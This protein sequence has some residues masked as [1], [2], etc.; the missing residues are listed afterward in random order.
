LEKSLAHFWLTLQVTSP[1]R[2]MT[3]GIPRAFA[4]ERIAV[5]GGA[6]YQRELRSRI[7][8]WVGRRPIARLSSLP[9]ANRSWPIPVETLPPLPAGGSPP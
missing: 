4:H 8:F 2:R 5:G 9:I 7:H 1:A 6:L 3:P